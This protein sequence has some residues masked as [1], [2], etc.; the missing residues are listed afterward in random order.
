MFA[1]RLLATVAIFGLGACGGAP[2][3][4]YDY[5]KEPDPRRMEYVIGVNDLLEIRV[6]KNPELSADVTVRPDGVITMPLLGDVRVEGRTPSELRGELKQRLAEFI[7]DVEPVVTIS[8]TGINS[9]SFTVGGNVERPG[10]FTSTKYVTVLEA[11]LLAGGPNKFAKA[12][13]IQLH[14]RG[15]DGKDRVIPVAYSLLMSGKRPEM[16][17]ALM[18]GDRIFVP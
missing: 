5:G 12:D 11:I 14:R 16:N 1:A 13:R 2:R 15:A 8:V 7:H 3:I 17:L 4:T 18:R 6:W 9:Y 10:V